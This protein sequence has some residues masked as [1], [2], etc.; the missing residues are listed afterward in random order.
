MTD[1]NSD[2][3]A[4]LT[5]SIPSVSGAIILGKRGFTLTEDESDWL[6]PFTPDGG[7]SATRYRASFI[8]SWL[9][10]KSRRSKVCLSVD[11]CWL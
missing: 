1:I 11:N 8:R 6:P 7:V 4:L 10:L 9:M 3:L 5:I 2:A